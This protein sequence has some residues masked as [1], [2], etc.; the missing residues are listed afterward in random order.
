MWLNLVERYYR[1]TGKGEAAGTDLGKYEKELTE[2][3]VNRCVSLTFEKELED[4]TM[5][6]KIL[7]LL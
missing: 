7:S 2:I 4:A 3:F 5:M 6:K 1:L